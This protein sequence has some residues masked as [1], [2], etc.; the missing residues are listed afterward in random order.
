VVKNYCPEDVPPDQAQVVTWNHTTTSGDEAPKGKY[1]FKVVNLDG[2]KPATDAPPNHHF[3]W[4]GH[5]FPMH[6]TP[7]TYGD[8]W[9]AGRGHRGTDIFESGYPSPCGAPLYAARAG[10]VQVRQY[11]GGGAGYYLVIDGNDTNRDYVYMHIKGSSWDATPRVGETVQ[12]GEKIAEVGKSGNPSACHLHFELWNGDWYGGGY[13][14]D[15]E[16]SLRNWDSWS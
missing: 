14:Y 16:P 9:G 1:K 6:G 11:Q 4:R 7:H 3:Q 12:T 5:I 13:A 8:G 2:T 10:A 15:S